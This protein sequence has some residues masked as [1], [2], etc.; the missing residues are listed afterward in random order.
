[1]KCFVQLNKKTL[2]NE[3]KYKIQCSTLCT[4]QYCES[5]EKESSI[6]KQ[7]DIFD[8][9]FNE[10]KLKTLNDWLKVPRKKLRLHLG[11]NIMKQYYKNNINNENYN[12]N[13]INEKKNNKKDSLSIFKNI[14]P[15]FP[16]K[17]KQ[18]KKSVL[19]SHR[20]IMEK[21]YTKFQLNSLD[22]WKRIKKSIFR[23]NG[24]KNIL[25]YYSNN[26]PHLLSSIYPHH[27]WKFD[28]KPKFNSELNKF[29]SLENQRIFM[30]KLYKKF[31][32]KSLNDWL[33]V[34]KI[35]IRKQGGSVLFDH[36]YPRDINKLLLTLYP[37]HNWQFNQ[38]S[39]FNSRNYFK[40][41][42]NQRKFMDDLFIKLKLNSLDDWYE[43]SRKKIVINGGKVLLLQYYKNDKEKLL[44]SIFPHHNWDW[45]NH[46]QE[47]FK[48]KKGYFS[49][50]ENQKIFMRKLFYHFKLN[51]LED[52][53]FLTKR[54]FAKIG[55]KILLIH[56]YKGDIQLLLS[57]LFPN[58]PWESD[59]LLTKDSNEY[60]KSLINQRKFMDNLFI[61]LQ[62]ETKDDWIFVSQCKFIKNQGKS[63]LFHYYDKDMQKM[64]KSIYPDHDWNFSIADLSLIDNQRKLMQKIFKDLNLEKNDDWL[65]VSRYQLLLHGGRKLLQIYGND[66]K[67]ILKEIYPKHDWNFSSL[68]FRPN[69]T[70]FKSSLSF[71]IE[72]L[73]QLKKIYSIEE[74]K[75]WYR[76]PSH[77]E[78]IDVF[79]S[80]SLVYLNEKWDKT[81]FNIR[82]KKINQRLLFSFLHQ[83]YSSS[84][85]IE[86]YR[87]PHISQSFSNIPMEFDVFIPS[88]SLAFEYQGEHHFNEI[89]AVF[90]YLDDHSSRDQ[91]KCELAKTCKIHLIVIPY[92][93]DQSFSS[94]ISSI[95]KYSP[96][97]I[98]VSY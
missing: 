24:A 10:L 71:N 96:N 13:D 5:R 74:K 30:D 1:M 53:I 80:L 50:I 70:Y 66:W 7:R 82:V 18:S 98:F 34:P 61:K 64:L 93:W 22:D 91:A 78:E 77:F 84:L 23:Q 8:H 68:K 62:L 55:G 46:N 51:K 85:L 90:S 37:H 81:L 36:F 25:N 17:F 31:G 14:Y 44:S 3:K 92:W 72:K 57:S 67:L 42:E 43:I 39:K 12:N 19:H 6:E 89:P 2:K 88:L 56:Y 75:D 63:L 69:A 29:S 47:I 95:T 9:A 27:N 32:L 38:L 4:A 83:I 28:E 94:L 11:N 86:N 16:W 45:K 33:S 59:L 76:L 73:K 49:L 35:S 15:N 58:Y 20:L 87:H 97:L 40:S 26:I 52:L 60:F 65:K 48:T 41:L 21:L 54:N 79:H